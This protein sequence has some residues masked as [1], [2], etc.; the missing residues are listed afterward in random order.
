M[1][2]FLGIIVFMLFLSSAKSQDTTVHFTQQE[3]KGFEVQVVEYVRN[4]CYYLGDLASSSTKEEE[5]PQ[6]KKN[7]RNLFVTP[8]RTTIGVVSLSR[9]KNP[10]NYTVNQYLEIVGKYKTKYKFIVLQF[11]KVRVDAR[12]LRD[13]VING[14]TLYVGTF[15]Y[16]QRFLASNEDK[17]SNNYTVDDFRKEGSD[18][19][20]KTGI[21]YIK[22]KE[23]KSSSNR[24]RWIVLLGDIKARSIKPL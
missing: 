12:H 8:D 21:F 20:Y 3:L 19:T 9:P 5:K 4:F 6:I 2:R 22:K 17:E 1:K 11:S 14:E 15:S 24:T 16:W 7:L 18:E 23:T 13:T 10:K